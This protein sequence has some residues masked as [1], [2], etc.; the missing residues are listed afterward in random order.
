MSETK[1]DIT[2]ILPV[3]YD[4]SI[5]LNLI[6]IVD[7]STRQDYC[8]LEGKDHPMKLPKELALEAQVDIMEFLTAH[9]LGYHNLRQRPESGTG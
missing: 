5:K 9:G 6:D 2:E 7:N 4:I 1:I 8:G 3:L